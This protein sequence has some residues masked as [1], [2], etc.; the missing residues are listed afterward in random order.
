MKKECTSAN[1]P[2]PDARLALEEASEAWH[3]LAQLRERRERFKNFAYGRQWDDRIRLADGRVLTEERA[4]V[5]NGRIPLTNNL[6]RQMIKSIVGRYR[7]MRSRAD[8]DESRSVESFRLTDTADSF[9]EPD[10]RALEEFLISGVAVQRVMTGNEDYS[11]RRIENI[12]PQR[13]FFAPFTQSDASDCRMVGML[14]DLSPDTALRI[15]GTTPQRRSELAELFTGRVAGYGVEGGVTDFSTPAVAGCVRIV[16]MWKREE[17]RML[18][19]L[20]TEKMRRFTLP[21]DSGSHDRLERI[22]RARRDAGRTGIAV[23]EEHL[24]TW[25]QRVMTPSGTL[26]HT[27]RALRHPFV[28]SLYPYIDGEVHSLVEDVVSQQKYVNRLITLLDDVLAASAK[29]VL[30]YPTDQLP[31]GLTWT[32]IRRIWA[33]PGGILPYRRTA[34]NVAPVQVQS[35]GT[36]AG[37]VE[38]LRTQLQLFEEI[39]GTSGSV[40]GK[41]S[42]AAGADM[43]RAEMEN[44]NISMLDILAAFHSFTHRRDELFRELDACRG[45]NRVRH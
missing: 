36:S 7:Y 10:A 19:C 16:E 15:Y 30:L 21:S 37:A 39:S 42:S 12:S 5:E 1:T 14:R 35:Q 3:S 28:L 45:D 17:T 4:S 6:I 13:I 20:D 41:T 18:R 27:S 11:P 31:D 29:G 9:A 23:R 24:S 2:L 25:V 40:R 32:D 38:M 22:N 33:S 44:A 8:D 26:I 43:L 34:R